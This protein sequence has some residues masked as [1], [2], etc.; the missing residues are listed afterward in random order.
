MRVALN[1]YYNY[2]YNIMDNHLQP[3][4]NEGNCE[5]KRYLINLNSYKIEKL[6]TQMNWRLVEGDNE[7]IYYLGVNDNG[8]LYNWTK[9]E[10]Q[11][12]IK[13]FRIILYK[14]NAKIIEFN[15]INSY[16]R[17]KIKKNDCFHYLW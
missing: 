4:N 1:I 9:K 14:S 16:F 15:K 17:I 6:I 5:Y 8:T 11:E 13:N 7:A 2:N 3:E 10:Q 12:T